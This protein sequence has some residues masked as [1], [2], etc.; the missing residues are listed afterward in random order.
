MNRAT[1]FVWAVARVFVSCLYREINLREKTF[2]SLFSCAKNWEV[3]FASTGWT[4]Y[5]YTEIPQKPHACAETLEG[6]CKY[7]CLT[8]HPLI[9]MSMTTCIGMVVFP[10]WWMPKWRYWEYTLKPNCKGDTVPNRSRDGKSIMVSLCMQQPFRRRQS[11]LSPRDYWSVS[12]NSRINPADHI[13]LQF[14]YVISTWHYTSELQ[15]IAILFNWY[16]LC[17]IVKCN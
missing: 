1:R 13:T 7:Y 16:M 3:E 4:M 2:R 10:H 17:N 15:H 6:T 14:N 12:S 8:C 9:Q 11:K 5:C